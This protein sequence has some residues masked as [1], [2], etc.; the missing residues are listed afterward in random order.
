MW[1]TIGK[2][3]INEFGSPGYITMAFPYLFPFGK[4]DYSMPRNTKLFLSDYIKFLMEFH[5]ERFAKDERFR[6]FIM[7]SQMRWNAIN[8]GSIVVKKNVFFSKLTVVQLKEHLKK[9]PESLKQIMF[10]SSRIRTT[11][12]YWNT[13]SSELLDFVFQRG[14]PT[15]F[16][17]LSSAD[18]HWPDVYR[19]LGYNVKTLSVSEK[20]KII[21]ENPLV[22]DTYFVL[23]A[24][25]FMEKCLTKHFQIDDYWYRFEFAHRGTIH[26]HGLLWMK[27]TPK[28]EDVANESV[29]KEIINFFDNIISC[30]NP[31]PNIIMDDIHPCEKKLSEIDDPEKDLAQLINTVQRHTK[32]TKLHCLRVK[33]GRGNLSCRYKANMDLSPIVNNSVVYRYIAKYTS[34]SE[35]MSISYG[36]ILRSVTKNVTGENENCKKLIR[37]VLISTCAERDYSAQEVMHY[38][39]GHPFYHSSR[40]FVVLNLKTLL[41]DAYGKSTRYKS[42]IDYYKE[43]PSFLNCYS[44]YDFAKNYSNKKGQLTRR[45]KSAIVR[46]FPKVSINEANEYDD[47]A[48]NAMFSYFIPC[49][50]MFEL[51]NEQKHLISQRTNGNTLESL[52][53]SY[54]DDED[55]EKQ[56]FQECKT[57]DKTDEMQILSTY[58]PHSSRKIFTIGTSRR[59]RD[60]DWATWDIDMDEEDITAIS[61]EILSEKQSQK[62]FEVDSS[63]LN[64]CQKEVMEFLNSQVNAVLQHKV[65]EGSITLIQGGAGSGKSH[66]LKNLFNAVVDK[67][68]FSSIQVTASTGVA[69]K[70]VSGRTINS[71]LKLGRNVRS[72]VPLVGDNLVKFQEENSNVQ[73]LFIDEYSMIGCR[74]LAII[75]E[76]LRQMKD[77]QNPFGKMFV[78]MFG[79]CN[80]LIPIGDLPIFMAHDSTILD[81]ICERGKLIVRAIESSYCLSGNL[82]SH[83]NAYTQFLRRLAR[84]NCTKDDYSALKNRIFTLLK[85]T[86]RISFENSIRICGT[87]E[88]V[89]QHNENCLLDL[90]NPIAKI[91]AENS[92]K[93]AFSST[94]DEADGLINVLNISVGAKVMLKR[95]LNVSRGLVNG[96]IGI[97]HKILYRKKQKPPS[98]PAFILVTFENIHI[99][100]LSCTFVPIKPTLASWTKGGTRCTRLQFPLV[101]SWAC[102]IH[103]S[104]GLSLLKLILETSESEYAIG[105]LYVA[106]SR[107][108]DIKS[109]CLLKALTMERLNSVRNSKY[110]CHRQKFLKWI[111][112]KARN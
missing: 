9:N 5:D 105:L 93:A 18:Y 44:L 28:S 80:Q 110:F 99:E 86:E 27:N 111:K 41:Y 71:Y 30:E 79:D 89:D 90:N 61:N 108:S 69:A 7:N 19:I 67:L 65:K 20:M 70:A 33:R 59:D 21:S 109:L 14:E 82:R 36:E 22:F 23:R 53:E 46:I 75:E 104:Q 66:L 85:N 43:R 88:Q 96:S 84:G 107:V 83:C 11:R 47:V 38:L 91:L 103:K 1:P 37:K 34:K 72:T 40:D 60:H 12:P 102:T 16:I 98:L 13:R 51:V 74:F 101:L 45:R 39:L 57:Q 32:C 15:A 4:G 68:G 100:D 10:Y 3:P 6:Y 73:F 26:L 24:K 31:D 17:T 49:D 48:L 35:G 62:K 8:V 56:I 64:D 106:L 50:E 95:N 97:V 2:T 112:E 77:I 81:S 52:L 29:Q 55:D 87:N 94:D 92:S 58:N 78:Y 42:I 76:R 63:S 54:Q 25:F